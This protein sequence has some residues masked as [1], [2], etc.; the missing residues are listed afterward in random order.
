MTTTLSFENFR[1]IT[2]K[3]ESALSEE[4]KTHIK[5]YYEN[6]TGAF[7][8]NRLRTLQGYNL[9]RELDKFENIELITIRHL[10]FKLEKW[11]MIAEEVRKPHCTVQ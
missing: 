2:L 4:D 3:K 9:H 1:Q 11:Q 8:T 5:T 7:C 6:K 10:L